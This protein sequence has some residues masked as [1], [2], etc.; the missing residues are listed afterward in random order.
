M[1]PKQPLEFRGHSSVSTGAT[2]YSDNCYKVWMGCQQYSSYDASDDRFMKDT[3]TLGFL[4]SVG[5][6]SSKAA[7][8]RLQ[9]FP[10]TQSKASSLSQTVGKNGNEEMRREQVALLRREGCIMLPGCHDAMGATLIQVVP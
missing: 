10:A 1:I 9:Y 4:S 5:L 3:R 7:D 6:T 2:R 8:L